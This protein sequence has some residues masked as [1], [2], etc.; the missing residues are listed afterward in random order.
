[1]AKP[2]GELRKL[3]S[4]TLLI[5][6]GPI[7]CSTQQLEINKIHK[8]QKI[9]FEVSYVNFAWGHQDHGIYIDRSGNVY[10]FEYGP[11]DSYWRPKGSP[12]PTEADFMERYSHNRK[13]L[14]KIP[15]D[16]LLEKYRLIQTASSGELTERRHT[17]YDAGAKIYQCFLYDDKSQGLRPVLLKLEGNE[18][19]E[20]LSPSAISLVSWLNQL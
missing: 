16:V 2:A 19:Q 10:S 14:K 11:K 20:N 1:M 13:F 18:S 9:L 8:T 4:L 17:A 3:L 5:I 7:G 15:S 6:I 12:N